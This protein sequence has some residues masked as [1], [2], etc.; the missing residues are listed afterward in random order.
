MDGGQIGCHKAFDMTTPGTMLTPI[1]PRNASAISSLTISMVDGA[2]PPAL[3]SNI[4]EVDLILACCLPPHWFAF[5][6]ALLFTLYD[7]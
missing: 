4:G 5:Y 6:G 2:R 1:L 7:S 3:W